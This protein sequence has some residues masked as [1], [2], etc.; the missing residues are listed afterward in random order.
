MICFRFRILSSERESYPE[1]AQ[2]NLR[3]SKRLSAIGTETNS[4]QSQGSSVPERCFS[5]TCAT[6]SAVGLLSF[7][8]KRVRSLNKGITSMTTT[9]KPIHVIGIC[10]FQLAESLRNVNRE[11]PDSPL[12]ASD[13]DTEN[14]ATDRKKIKH[15]AANAAPSNS[16]EVVAVQTSSLLC[17]QIIPGW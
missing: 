13:S 9:P 15:I 16:Q 2:R 12:A 10:V 3:A 5:I 17:E 4:S 7:L 6:C 8:L 1:S 14:L 11:G